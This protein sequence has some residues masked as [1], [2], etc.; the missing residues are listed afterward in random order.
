MYVAV[1][2]HP[3]LMWQGIFRIQGHAQ[4]ICSTSLFCMPT[5]S[6][7]SSIDQLSS[8]NICSFPTWCRS[9]LHSLVQL[10]QQLLVV[11]VLPSLL[12]LPEVLEV[13]L[14]DQI[15]LEILVVLDHQAS[16]HVHLF[17]AN[18]LNHHDLKVTQNWGS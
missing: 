5:P 6:S 1:T 3:R 17:H 8:C 2:S 12:A 14:L 4:V 18:H 11:L 15:P 10:V 16:H 7:S 13:H 9:P